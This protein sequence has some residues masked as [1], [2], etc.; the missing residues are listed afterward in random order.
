M[1]EACEHELL[2]ENTSVGFLHASQT[3]EKLS[4]MLLIALSECF[5][6]LTF[7]SFCLPIIPDYPSLF[8]EIQLPSMILVQFTSDIILLSCQ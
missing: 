3:R 5:L 7:F 2:S 4:L 8:L 1:A 6:F